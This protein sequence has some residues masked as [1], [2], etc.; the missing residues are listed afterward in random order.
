MAPPTSSRGQIYSLYTFTCVPLH[1]PSNPSLQQRSGSSLNLICAVF[2]TTQLNI[3]RQ[4]KGTSFSEH[5][6]DKLNAIA[7][8]IEASESD[9]SS[10][11]TARL[12]NSL[13]SGAQL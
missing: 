3:Y 2:H 4:S 10:F 9:L 13:C 1:A 8:K 5:C 7:E 6:G 12:A 11:G